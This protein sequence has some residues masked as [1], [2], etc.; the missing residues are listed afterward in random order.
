LRGSE[1]RPGDIVLL[2]TG[3]S[4]DLSPAYYERVPDIT[5]AAA[6]LLACSGASIIGIDAGSID[7]EPFPV[8]KQV[9]G[10]GIL[11]AE[12]LI[13]L[14]QLAGREF[15]VTALPLRLGVDG[16]PARVVASVAD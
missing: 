15:T 6:A 14:A 16:A 1:I 9:L 12:N 2:W 8:H 11:L 3:F 5:P 10:A 13:G 4:D 7:A